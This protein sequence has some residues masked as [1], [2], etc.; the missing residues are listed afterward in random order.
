MKVS[1]LAMMLQEELGYG[2]TEFSQKVRLSRQAVCGMYRRG[3][4]SLHHLMLMVDGL[5][6]R[7]GDSK[8]ATFK[9]E[10]KQD[11][12]TTKLEVGFG[13]VSGTNC[14]IVRDADAGVVALTELKGGPM[15][16]I[17]G[18]CTLPAAFAIC[19]RTK[20]LYQTIAVYDP[21]LLGYVVAVNNGG[22]HEIGQLIKDQ[23]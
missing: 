20:H 11:D 5:K 12:L 22:S 23:A 13:D 2:V 3:D 14:E 16:L 17:S 4:K 18:P 15:L 7:K 1:P 6:Y 19:N 9:I 10:M 8:V 21:K